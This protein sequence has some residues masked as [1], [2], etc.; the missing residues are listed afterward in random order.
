[1]STS[2]LE[3]YN[4]RVGQ[5]LIESD[6]AQ[7]VV[8][9]KLDKL[10]AALADYQPAPK[11][12]GL[13]RLFGARRPEPFLPGLYIWGSVGRGKTMLMDLFFE[14]APQPR[15]RRSH[16]HAFMADV[17]AAIYAWRQAEKHKKAKGDDPIATVADA[18]AEQALLLC[19]DEFHVTDITDAMILGR[20]F[21]AL[22]ERG[23]VI[24][25]TSNV[26]P[27]NLYKDGLNRA[28]FVPFISLIKARMEV[29]E[30]TARTDFRREK[31]Q[32][33]QTFYVPP[34]EKSAAALT[35]AFEA[36]TG[37][38][39][40][41]PMVLRVL[42]R[43][44]AVPEA[45][46]HV[47][48]FSFADLCEAPLGPSDYLYIARYFHTV[49]IDEIPVIAPGRRDA[50]KRF[51]TLIDTLY[52]EHV[53]LIASAAAEPAGLYVGADGREAFE[54][55][56]TVSRLIEMRSEAYMALPHGSIASLGTGDASGLVET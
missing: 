35:G 11:P 51:I 27:D 28:L 4:D 54:F 33:R 46:A 16:F 5:G 32:G 12:S 48:R 49:I 55:D 14:E 2:L 44:L 56:R 47:G 30:L 10:R 43:S 45:H 24:V 9:R 3:R 42:G 37:V 1:M 17:H 21:T 53:K 34:D 39:R 40:G 20:L 52:D 6:E 13:S 25:A 19:F 18:I 22:S 8:L 7:E 41:K 50:V 36:L 23:V 29:I 31:L 15:K 26:E 38:E